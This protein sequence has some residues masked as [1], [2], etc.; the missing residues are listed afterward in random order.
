MSHLYF[1]QVSLAATATVLDDGKHF[2]R[3]LSFA[4][5]HQ[6][7]LGVIIG[8]KDDNAKNGDVILSFD[9]QAAER[10]EI[11]DGEL[12]AIIGD[13]EQYYRAGQSF[14]VAGGTAL[15]LK[16][17]GIVQYVRHLEG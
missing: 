3:L 1:S 4:D 15:R 5:G 13:E 11:T 8:D 9:N 2:T 6:K 14:V 7:V 12:L 10:I 16:V 17:Q